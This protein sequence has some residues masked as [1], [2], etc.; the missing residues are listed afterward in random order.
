M[1]LYYMLIKGKQTK[2]LNNTKMCSNQFKLIFNISSL[3]DQ[4][5]FL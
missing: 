4:V 5:I 1:K 2:L 3:Q